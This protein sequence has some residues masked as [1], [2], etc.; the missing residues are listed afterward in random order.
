M[1]IVLTYLPPA[2]PAGMKGSNESPTPVCSGTASGWY[3]V[4]RQVLLGLPL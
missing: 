4:C 2:M 1:Q 3:P